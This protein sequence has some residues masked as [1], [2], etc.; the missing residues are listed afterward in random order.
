MKALIVVDVQY[1]FC[2]GG[3]L[4]VA[5]GNALAKILG[6]LMPEL[7]KEY[8]MVVFTQD[9]HMDPGDHFSDDPDFIDSWPKHCVA[10]TKGAE[11]HESIG[12]E[13][14]DWVIQKGHYDAGYSGFSNSTMH[15]ALKLMN[16]DEVHVCGI[17][18]EH[19]VKQTAMDAVELGYKTLILEELTA[20]IKND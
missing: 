4:A 6:E 3:A 7:R 11:L 13:L 17:A 15:S 12:H 5:G 1:D 20:K 10:G 16:I 14:G 2:E 9:W 8:D 18:R 19:C